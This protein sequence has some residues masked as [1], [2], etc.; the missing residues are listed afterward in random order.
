MSEDSESVNPCLKIQSLDCDICATSK[1]TCYQGVLVIL[2]SFGKESFHRKIL[3][4]HRERRNIIKIQNME[5]AEK[6][7]SVL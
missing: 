6:T 4:F 5:I 7:P 3:C 1:H 2:K